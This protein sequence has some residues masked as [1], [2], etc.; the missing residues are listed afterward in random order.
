MIF[1]GIEFSEA[2]RWIDTLSDLAFL[3]MDLKHLGRGELAAWLLD[4]YLS[5]NGDYAGLPL[6]R[7]YEVYRAMVRAKVAAIRAEQVEGSEAREAVLAEYLRYL[8]LAEALVREG[9]GAI[10][11]TY[12]VSGSG[13]SH[14]AGELVGALHAV[15]VRSDV[16]R[17]RLAGV[18]PTGDASADLEAGIYSAE[19]TARTYRR[20]EDL[21]QYIVQAGG[22]AVVDATFLKQARRRPFVELAK[23]LGVPWLILRCQA[24]EEVLRERVRRRHAA[25]G[26]ASDADLRVLEAQLLQKESL[27]AEEREHSLVVSPE[28][29]LDP[30]AVA[31]RL[32]GA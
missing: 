22:V 2:L 8:R 18:A 24:P 32:W 26:D 17:K 12:G 11:L 31:A 20:L 25:G 14:W 21:A 9:R 7:L 1:D 10:V 27:N 3:T 16:E 5:E 15:R 28:R 6:L 23:T 13:K 29:P 4:A 19:M 30:E